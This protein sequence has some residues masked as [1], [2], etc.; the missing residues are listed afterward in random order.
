M[1]ANIPLICA[2]IAIVACVYASY[3]DLKSGI[4]SNKLTLP[5]IGVGI[6]LNAI[7]AFL[8]GDLWIIIYCLIF[9]AV[10]YVISYIF[11]RMGAWAG[12]DAKLFTALAALLPFQPFIVKYSVYGMNF[13]VI[14]AYGFPITLILNSIISLLPFLLIYVLYLVLS[15]K[16]ELI[17]E[18]ISPI[19]EYKKNL[20]SAFTVTSSVTLVV[21]L[22]PYL[23]SKL[24]IFILI[25]IIVFSIVISLLPKKIKAVVLLILTL[26]G[27]YTGFQL[28]VVSIVMLL[29]SLTI[30]RVILK[31]LT[32]ITRKALQ[33]DFKVEELK[34]GMIPAF[35][36]YE[37][38]DKVIVDDK[39]IMDKIKES[40]KKGDLFGLMRPEGKLVISTMAAGLSKEDIQHLKKLVDE[41]KMENNVTIKKGIEFAPSILI[42]LII[43][44]FIGDLVLILQKIFFALYY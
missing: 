5:L 8:T 23:P 7:H 10:I 6:I 28:T 12:G 3:S 22:F 35:K 1:F 24:M 25:F 44:L 37:G 36:I 30:I 34:E 39:G 14:S 16:R 41:N 2:I 27:L 29:I 21:L 13:P 17:D 43:S 26:Y 38:E 33:N 9:I 19:K 18:L 15:S 31:I 42:G 40:A 11:W 4:I 32:S 20:V